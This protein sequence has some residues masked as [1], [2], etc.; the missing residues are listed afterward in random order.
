[1]TSGESVLPE[2]TPTEMTLLIGSKFLPIAEITDPTILPAA[3]AIK[4][5]GA[6][7]DL[8]AHVLMGGFLA[9]LSEGAI[10]LRYVE[11]KKMRVLKSRHVM[12]EKVGDSSYDRATIEGGLFQ[13]VSSSA[14]LSVKQV[15][16]EWFGPDVENPGLRAY[17]VAWDR[18]ITMGMIVLESVPND[19]GKPQEVARPN[20]QLIAQTLPQLVRWSE[21]WTTFGAEERELSGHLFSE[22]K[23]TLSWK[24]KAE[25]DDTDYT[26]F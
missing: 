10:S 4:G 22:I 14:P 21:R 11:S 23:R 18:L 5:K 15:V 25:S 3:T 8:G 19:K 13:V 6:T 26:D 2:M 24:K 17:R 1:M 9:L 16:G 7:L 20:T 12:V